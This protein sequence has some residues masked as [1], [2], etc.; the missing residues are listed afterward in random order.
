MSCF[1]AAG[2]VA[3]PVPRGDGNLTSLRVALGGDMGGL[4]TRTGTP[5]VHLSECDEGRLPPLRTRTLQRL[6][7]DRDRTANPGL[8]KAERWET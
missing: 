7:E 2:T 1:D 3:G 4:M 8:S 6:F 5:K